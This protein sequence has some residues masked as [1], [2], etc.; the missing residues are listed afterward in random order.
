LLTF[1]VGNFFIPIERSV[2]RTML[3]NDFL[4]FY[5]AGHFLRTG[6]LDKIYDLPAV[7]QYQSQIGRENGLDLGAGFGPFWNP[8]FYAW[9]FAPLAGLPYETA[10]TIWWSINLACL[11][12]SIMLLMRLLP[13]GTPW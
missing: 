11:A 3:G 12:V 4:A 6:Q 10:L 2:T 9:I 1:V 5:T 7:Q 8:P 13:P